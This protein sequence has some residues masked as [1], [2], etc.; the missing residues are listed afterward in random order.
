M[1]LEKSIASSGRNPLYRCILV[2]FIAQNR[3]T[4]IDLS[5]RRAIDVA[6]KDFPEL[7]PQREPT[8]PT[9]AV[10][11]RRSLL[12]VHVSLNKIVFDKATT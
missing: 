8:L 3:E 12:L 1:A 9:A 6:D 2:Q 7:E 11:D 10:R 5:R 4:M